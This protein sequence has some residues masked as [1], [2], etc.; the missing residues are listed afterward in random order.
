MLDGFQT[1]LGLRLADDGNFGC[2]QCAFVVLVFCLLSAGVLGVFLDFRHTE[3]K[4]LEGTWVATSLVVDGDWTPADELVK[5]QVRL[6]G[7]NFTMSMPEAKYKGQWTIDC[8]KTREIDFLHGFGFRQD[9][10]YEVD[11]DT[12]RLCLSPITQPRPTDFTAEKGSG[13]T[14]IVLKRQRKEP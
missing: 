14:L 3:Q 7:S 12:M 1:L 4:A 13:R 9:A 2:R 8:T 6:Y 11:S 10:I 5:V